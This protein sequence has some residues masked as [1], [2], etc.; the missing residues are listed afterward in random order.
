MDFA[1]K[2]AAGWFRNY[3]SGGPTFPIQR[4]SRG[5]ARRYLYQ[6]LRRAKLDLGVVGSKGSLSDYWNWALPEDEEI[7]NA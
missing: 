5:P 4:R 7:A 3:L 1:N 6:T 2:V